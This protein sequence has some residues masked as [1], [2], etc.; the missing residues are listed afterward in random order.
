MRKM[1]TAALVATMLGCGGAPVATPAEDAGIDA[2]RDAGWPPDSGEVPTDCTP[3][4]GPCCSG[5]GYFMLAG[6]P[7]GA[8]PLGSVSCVE[9][10]SQD[11]TEGTVRVLECSGASSACAIQGPFVDVTFVCEFGCSSAMPDCTGNGIAGCYAPGEF[12]SVVCRGADY[13][14][15]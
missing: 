10:P 5:S 9:L 12:A 4:D 1:I 11:W 8:G 6:T 15:E 2:G 3:G 14:G 7:C 13:L